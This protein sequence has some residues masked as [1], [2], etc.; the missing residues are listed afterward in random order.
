MENNR[1]FTIKQERSLDIF[2]ILTFFWRKKYRIIITAALM[3]SLGAYY[4]LH[5]PKMYVASSILLLSAKDSGLTLPTS[6][7]SITSGED[8]RQ[9]TYIEFMRSRQF[10]QTVVEDLALSLIHI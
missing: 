2:D 3:A 6:L 10:V 8:S 4:V 9:D 7:S 5:L 1:E